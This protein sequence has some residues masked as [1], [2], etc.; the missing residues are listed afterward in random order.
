MNTLD[1]AI[2]ALKAENKR[3]T[4]ELE[5]VRAAIGALTGR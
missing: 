1:Q 5:Q 3:L 4:N 2:A